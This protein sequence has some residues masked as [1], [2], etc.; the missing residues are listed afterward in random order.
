MGELPTPTLRAE[1]ARSVAQL[2]EWHLILDQ[3]VPAMDADKILAMLKDDIPV[4]F[5]LSG[6][7]V[8]VADRNKPKEI[9]RLPTWH[10]FTCRR[11]FGFDRI[12]S[13]PG[14]ARGKSALVMN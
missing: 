9:E 7:N 3:R 10:G 5:D 2:Q 11:G 13:A 14:N 8:G 1:V 4:S 6:L 12:N